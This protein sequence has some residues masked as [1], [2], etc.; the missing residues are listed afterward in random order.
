[1]S[2]APPATAFIVRLV[3]SYV[4]GTVVAPL[5]WFLPAGAAD[6]IA[7]E[8]LS[9]L[10]GLAALSVMISFKY[11]LLALVLALLFRRSIC[12]HLLIWCAGAVA[13]VPILW[14]IEVYLREARGKEL[15]SFLKDAGGGALIVGYYAFVY[16]AVFYAW[17]R[18]LR[19]QEERG[20]SLKT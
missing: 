20:L 10:T 4:A 2:S 5:L 11:F 16:A 9:I 12:N 8:S 19:D 7:W 15:L 6:T 18:V 3:V 1:M 13:A 14:L 17:N